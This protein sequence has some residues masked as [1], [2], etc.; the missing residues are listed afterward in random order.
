MSQVVLDI[1]KVI[2]KFIWEDTVPKIA[3]RLLEIKNKV[4]KSQNLFQELVYSN[5]DNIVLSKEHTYN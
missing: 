4:Q 2:L 3:I 5:Q 1:N